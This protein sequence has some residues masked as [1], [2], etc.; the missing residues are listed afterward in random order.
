[1]EGTE[2]TEGTEVI[3]EVFMGNGTNSE[4]ARRVQA[5]RVQAQW[6]AAQQESWRGAVESGAVIFK[7][8]PY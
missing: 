8:V 4:G 2:G 1:M 7:W 3:P 5:R 6:R